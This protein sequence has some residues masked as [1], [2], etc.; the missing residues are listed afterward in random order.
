MVSP[1]PSRLNFRVLWT[2]QLLA[3]AGLTVMVPF[4]P[5]YM[6]DLGV[7][8]AEA[9]LWSGLALAAPAVTLLVAAPLWGR[10]GDHVGRKWMMVRA[11]AGLALSLVLMGFA[12][13]PLQFLLCRLFQGACGGVVDAAAAFASAE[14][15]QGTRGRVLGGLQ[16]ATAV[17]SL[18]GPLLGGPLV[19]A[20]GLRPLLLATGLLTGLSALATLWLLRETR[21]TG[22]AGAPPPVLGALLGVLRHRQT[23]AFALAGLCA[24]AGVYGLVTVFAPHVRALLAEPGQAATWVGGLQA[25]TWAAGAVGAP[26]WG[27]RN[28]TGA[29]E[30]RFAVAALGCAV[31]VALQGLS[32]PVGWLLPL[33][34]L[35][36]FCFSAL[37]QSVL[38]RLGREVSAEHQGVQM[39]V[40]NTFLTLGQI[41][42]AAAG[43]LLAGLLTPSWIFV[44][45]AGCF[46]LAATLVWMVR[47]NP[48]PLKEGAVLS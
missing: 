22:P 28:D 48:V 19:D 30:P 33:R 23:R 29:V 47:T 32:L 25:A 43:A 11:L 6:E 14:A 13:T 2:G 39:G 42:G 46:V 34:A 1:E 9:R 44:L 8:G 38:L 27:R 37:A 17:G 41:A 4:L 36:G 21:R 20:W 10:L 5:F 15:P 16:S 18:S 12:A 7:H 45:M 24:Q 40:A 35:Q 3:I 31:G 26:W